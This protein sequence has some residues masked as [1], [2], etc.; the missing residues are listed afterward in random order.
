[1]LF[2]RFFF[3]LGGVFGLFLV[4]CEND[5]RDVERVSSKAVSIPVDRSQ[6]VEIILSD[7]AIVKGKMLAPVLN[8][9]KTK[10][11]YFE[12]PKGVTL[13]LLDTTG[14]EKSRVTSDYGIYYEQT[15]QAV[16]RKNVVAVSKEGSK[17]F[18]SEELIYDETLKKFSS[19]ELVSIV[20]PSQTIYGTSFWADES[21][22]RYEIIQ[23]NGNFD[24]PQNS[25][26]PE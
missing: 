3:M 18:K 24:V 19:S 23:S 10:K 20:T 16:L 5:L 12:M 25:G 8:H 21:F 9:F 26:L 1:M 7:S 17:T 11:P 6:E 4:S 22:N 13:I 14:K 15:K 2:K